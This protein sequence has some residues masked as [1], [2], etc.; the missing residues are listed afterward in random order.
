M[1]HPYAS[2]AYAKAFGTNYEPLYLKESECWVLKRQIPGTDCFDA[3]G[4][5]PLSPIASG[6]KLEEDFK[7][8]RALGLV[9]LVLVSDP[10]FRPDPDILSRVFD[11]AMA[12]KEHYIND[13]SLPELY[14][15][16]NHRYK[17]NRAFRD[18]EIKRIELADYLNEWCALY[19][20]LIIKHE[21]RGVQA[22]S[23]DY[24]KKLCML[25]PLTMGAFINSELIACQLWLEHDGYGY[26]HLVASN[27]RGYELRAAYALYDF[28]LRY[29]R[30]RGARCVDL[31]GG[32]GVSEASSGLA[33]LK[34][35]FSTTTR[36]CYLCG[37]ILL[38]DIYDRLSLG[39]DRPFFPKYRG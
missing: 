24:F 5:Y 2:E 7:E 22:F 31:G 33:M 29:F 37:K 25:E 39:K 28:S 11:V 13:F 1:M 6:A 19:D 10:F 26:S 32:A 27:E 14:A 20:A 16:K 21:M 30:D 15:S 9:S 38:P 17:V 3:M 4:C 34:K 23:H 8:L 18:C 35:G 12:Y 36:M